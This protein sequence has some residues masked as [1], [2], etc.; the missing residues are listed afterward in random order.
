MKLF[1]CGARSGNPEEWSQWNELSLVL[2]ETAEQCSEFTDKTPVFEV[3]MTKPAL[4]VSM[5]EP[6]WGDDL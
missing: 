4:L 1:V 6:A 5:S 3:D 2:A